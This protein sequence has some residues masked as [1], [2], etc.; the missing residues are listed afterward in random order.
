MSPKRASSPASRKASYGQVYDTYGIEFDLSSSGG[1]AMS[2]SPS[3]GGWYLEQMHSASVDV[4]EEDRAEYL[5][6]RRVSPLRTFSLFLIQ[7]AK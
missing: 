2:F 7:R 1:G 3:D 5:A 6:D 4:S